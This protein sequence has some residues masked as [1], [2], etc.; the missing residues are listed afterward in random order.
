MCLDDLAS[1]MHRFHHRTLLFGRKPKYRVL[2][3]FA[4]D[5][6]AVPGCTEFHKVCA[7]GDVLGHFCLDL[8][9]TLPGQVL[10]AIELELRIDSCL[11]C[12]RRG[13]HRFERRE[14]CAESDDVTS[15]KQPRPLGLSA[16]D[17]ISQLYKR[18]KRPHRIEHGGEAVLETDLASF[19]SDSLEVV[20][21]AGQELNVGPARPRH[22]MHIAVD[23]S[24]Q[25]IV[26]RYIDSFGA[27]RYLY[28]GRGADRF[29]QFP[30]N[31]YDAVADGC[32]PVAVNYGGTCKGAASVHRRKKAQRLPLSP[33]TF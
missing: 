19:F 18:M 30:L 3:D 9:G 12:R 8:L 17:A 31:E 24:G 32:T 26:A 7:L 5:G 2:T 20:L 6:F 14:Y 1:G 21:V 13:F 29:D 28:L 10:S 22:Q 23:E 11:K 16:V 4:I 33:E 15:H 25:D 27:A